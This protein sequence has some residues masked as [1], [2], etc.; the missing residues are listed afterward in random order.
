MS[1]EPVKVRTSASRLS[2]ITQHEGATRKQSMLCTNR[3][4]E[5]IL[6]Q[7]FTLLVRNF[8]NSLS[9]IGKHVKIT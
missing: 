9:R 7:P 8:T 6:V 1:E 2:L 3:L 5:V 4:T